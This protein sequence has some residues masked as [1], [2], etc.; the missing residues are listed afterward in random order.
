MRKKREKKPRDTNKLLTKL[1]IY[2][3]IVLTIV[4]SFFM[5]KDYVANLQNQFEINAQNLNKL[6][7][8]YNVNEILTN[9]FVK[10]DFESLKL[11]CALENSNWDLFKDGSINSTKYNNLNNVGDSLLLTDKEAG[12]L[13]NSVLNITGNPDGIDF[14]EL[15]ITKMEN[16]SRISI[17]TIF[18]FSIKNIF[19]IDDELAE[20]LKDLNITLPNTTHAISECVIDTL[21]NKIVVAN[22]SYNQLDLNASKPITDLLNAGK[23]NKDDYIQN[24]GARLLLAMN[25]E[26]NAKTGTTTVFVNGGLNYIKA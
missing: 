20:A 22:I 5:I 14:K 11:K 9:A 8:T 2:T 7:D 18:T 26:L 25:S 21:T 12:T 10:D 13:M 15:T 6:N 1:A 16:S 4:V 24:F 17:K 19:S 23:E 3:T